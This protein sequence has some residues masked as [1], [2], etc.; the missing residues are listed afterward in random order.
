MTKNEIFNVIISSVNIVLVWILI[1]IDW[2]RIV[3]LHA[4]KWTVSI[5]SHNK[6]WKCSL[7]G[8]STR[9][10]ISIFGFIFN[11]LKFQ[12][13]VFFSRIQYAYT[14]TYQLSI[15]ESSIES[16]WNLCKNCLISSCIQKYVCKCIKKCPLR[17]KFVC[18]NLIR[19]S[20]KLN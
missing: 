20:I 14:T 17:R 10:T 8:F 2:F 3:F 18:N 6:L 12:K 13:F 11:V 4:V 16:I 5:L 1:V 7:H 19:I 9:F 15:S